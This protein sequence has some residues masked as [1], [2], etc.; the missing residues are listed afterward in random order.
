MKKKT[1]N[2]LDDWARWDY[3][4][5][6]RSIS[7]RFSEPGDPEGVW[8]VVAVQIRAFP[9]HEF[10]EE[11]RDLDAIV[12]KLAAVVPSRKKLGKGKWRKNRHSPLTGAR[13]DHIGFLAP[14]ALWNLR[15]KAEMNDRSLYGRSLARELKQ[16]SKAMSADGACGPLHDRYGEI[17]PPP[18]PPRR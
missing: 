18:P 7:S 2:A 16:K 9:P 17:P 1:L 13:T 10:R 5:Y 14:L 12:A 4:V 3:Y 15:Y 11:G 6:L 8:W